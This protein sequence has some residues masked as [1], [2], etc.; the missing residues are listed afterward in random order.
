LPT[1]VVG[2]NDIGQLSRA[3]A[4][5]ACVVHMAGPFA[6]TWAPMLSAC[7]ATRTNYVDIT[8]EIAVFEAMWSRKEEID[9]SGITAVPGGGFDVVPTDCL[10]AYVASKSTHPTAL[11]LALR[12][13]ESASQGTLRTAL[14]EAS[15][16][17]LCRRSGTIV[18]LADRSARWVDFDAGREPCIAVSWGDIATAFRTT[19]IKDITVYFRRTPLLRAADTIGPLIGPVLQT[20][21]AQKALRAVIRRFPEGP[22]EAERA[23]HRA[24]I[25]AEAT[26]PSG[27]SE[28]AILSTPDP[29]DFTANCALEISSRLSSLPAPLG[30]VTPAQ[31]FG[32]DFVLS[33]PGCSRT[34]IRSS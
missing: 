22:S 32:A 8:G 14:R 13:L 9:R 2:L 16:P 29:Y 5:I 20:R 21:I 11:T 17:V 26:D 28:R 30:L 31:A 33:L 19:G 7:L 25:W 34:D 3:L 23:V 1:R 10:A 6:T 4:D 15:K 12:G 18:P 24:T 27:R